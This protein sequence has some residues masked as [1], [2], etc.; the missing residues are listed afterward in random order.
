[1][2]NKYQIKELVAQAANSYNTCGA[3]RI[4]TIDGPAGAGKTTLAEELSKELGNC[5]AI[6]MDDLYQ[7]WQ[8][9]LKIELTSR[10]AAWILT[11]LEYGLTGQYLKFNWQTKSYD[12]IVQVQPAEFLILEGVG[13]GHPEIAK[14]AALSVWI[15]GDPAA[16]LDRLI[17]RDGQEFQDE[18]VAW[19][20]HEA[21]YFASLPVKESAQV[22]I[23][24]D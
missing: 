22:Q 14:K 9:D 8:Q 6:H 17:K 4:I 3:T 7:S 19:Q 21:D 23:Q 24:A 11:P 10:I 20:R 15:Q 12:Q 13:A 2:W 5:Q 1:M 16:L 18:L